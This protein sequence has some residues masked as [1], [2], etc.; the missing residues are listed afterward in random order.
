SASVST[1]SLLG[2][3]DQ[4]LNRLDAALHL[5]RELSHPFS[6]AVALHAAVVL[7]HHRRDAPAVQEWAEATIEI[8]T[9]HEYPQWLAPMLVF[10][11]W[12]MAQR[13]DVLD[14]ISQMQQGLS[15]YQTMRAGIGLPQYFGLMAEIYGNSGQVPK[16]LAS[17]IEALTL[18][19]TKGQ[20]VY[21]AEI[22]RLQGELLLQD[23]PNRSE[24]AAEM[25]FLKSLNSAR[26]QGMKLR[27]LR[28]AVHL[29]RLWQ[30]QGKRQ[31][32]RNLL[33]PVYNGFTE[34]F[35]TADLQEAHALLAELRG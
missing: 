33:A 22:Y 1:L 10:R 18:I 26:G 31:K 9:D 2:Y 5:A 13:G 7:Y 6:Y 19:K 32:A 20:R 4:A 16:G 12:A 23:S 24:L 11:G 3:A 34:G 25:S 8:A 35:D 14:G 29:G 30:H 21:E 17:L 28:A 15:T 27:E